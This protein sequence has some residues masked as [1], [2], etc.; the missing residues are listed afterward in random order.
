MPRSKAFY[1]HSNASN[2]QTSEHSSYEELMAPEAN[3]S[4]KVQDSS[5]PQRSMGLSP[6]PVVEE[7]DEMSLEER[8]PVHAPRSSSL[9]NTT[10]STSSARSYMDKDLPA[11]PQELAQ[12]KTVTPPKAQA[13]TGYRKRSAF[14]ISHDLDA[15]SQPPTVGLPALPNASTVGDSSDSSITA[16]LSKTVDNA[17]STTQRYIADSIALPPTTYDPAQPLQESSDV[18]NRLGGTSSKMIFK[19]DIFRREDKENN[20]LEDAVSPVSHERRSPEAGSTL[21][22]RPSPNPKPVLGPAPRPTAA[23]TRIAAHMKFFDSLQKNLAPEAARPFSKAFAAFEMEKTQGSSSTKAVPDSIQRL[24]IKKVTH[25]DT[26]HPSPLLPQSGLNGSASDSQKGPTAC[27]C[28][29]GG[30]GYQSS[31]SR[32]CDRCPEGSQAL[33]LREANRDRD[34]TSNPCQGQGS[35]F[36]S[37]PRKAATASTTAENNMRTAAS[38]LGNRA[39]S[40]GASIKDVASLRSDWIELNAHDDRAP[41]RKRAVVAAPRLAEL[42]APLNP[43]RR[44]LR[45]SSIML[46]G[47]IG[48]KPEDQ[49]PELLRQ[50]STALIRLSQ[51]GSKA[52]FRMLWNMAV[53]VHGT[54]NMLFEMRQQYAQKGRLVLRKGQ[55]LGQVMYDCSRS[56]FYLVA[57]LLIARLGFM[58]GTLLM[59]MVGVVINAV[60]LLKS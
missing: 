30:A 33:P 7:V 55:T 5:R 32:G 54:I 58:F 14:S 4:R 9:P 56:T 44:G 24:N 10:Y 60:G 8:E 22:T 34:E 43:V 45:R 40:S 11:L 16:G 27:Q 46:R 38:N 50:L 57:L 6:L 36:Q 47:A 59:R 52:A 2:L 31:M 49:V 39:I 19:E 17:A 28:G 26:P 23:S 37:A 3:T 25:A 18:H 42:E 51:L 21:L 13:R 53:S 29:N 12:V 1:E 48:A 20:L 35:I 41:F 15:D